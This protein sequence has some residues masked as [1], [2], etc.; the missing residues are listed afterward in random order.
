MS[1]YFYFILFIFFGS[2]AGLWPLLLE[3]KLP[4]FCPEEPPP[5]GG[6][7][8]NPSFTTYFD[9]ATCAITVYNVWKPIEDPNDHRCTEEVYINLDNG[10]NWILITPEQPVIL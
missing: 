8:L 5:P 3:S 7:Q 6:C 9:H 10:S 1:R 2:A 4:A